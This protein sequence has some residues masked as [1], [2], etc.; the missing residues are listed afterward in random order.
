[1]SPELIA[2]GGPTIIIGVF[3]VIF[4]QRLGKLQ[5]FVFVIIVYVISII[6]GI[7][8]YEYV[9]NDSS[10][11]IAGVI[12]PLVY[13]LIFSGIMNFRPNIKKSITHKQENIQTEIKSVAQKQEN[14]PSA[15]NQWNPMIIAALIQAVASIIVALITIFGK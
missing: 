9:G 8:S 3:L 11:V 2:F 13:C 6:T 4:W 15:T 7:F 14:T 1:M 5:K 12:A 10:A